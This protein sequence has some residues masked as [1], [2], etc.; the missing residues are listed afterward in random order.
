MEADNI[1]TL[2]CVATADSAR[3]RVRNLGKEVVRLN[4]STLHGVQHR[5]GMTCLLKHMYVRFDLLGHDR[6]EM[7]V[8]FPSLLKLRIMS[9]CGRLLLERS[10]SRPLSPTSRCLCL[11]IQHSSHDLQSMY[12]HADRRRSEQESLLNTCTLQHITTV[13]DMAEKYDQLE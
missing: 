11:I 9:Y 13:L 7:F 1:R 2:Q 10:T 8:V 3:N 4:V 12:R 6:R 5:T